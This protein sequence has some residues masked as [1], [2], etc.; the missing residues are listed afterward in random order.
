M[1]EHV[2]QNYRMKINI[3]LFILIGVFTSTSATSQVEILPGK[4]ILFNKDSILIFKCSPKVLCEIFN[5]KDTNEINQISIS[6]YDSKG[7]S[8]DDFFIKSILFDEFEFQFSG[9][10]V[11]KLILKNIYINLSN[12]KYKLLLS[13]NEIDSTSIKIT[14]KF[15]KSIR[16]EMNTHSTETFADSSYS[17]ITFLL[18]KSNKKI[19]KICVT[20]I[21]K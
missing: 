18:D 5:I 2:S 8:I 20:T 15:R 19:L 14:K 3:I 1:H 10:S 13:N 16:K 12:P 6:E 21:D 4:G 17:G 11:D 7:N 9:Y